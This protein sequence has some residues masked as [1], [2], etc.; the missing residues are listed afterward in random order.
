MCIAPS[1][2]HFE[3]VSF[4]N[5]IWTIKGGAHVA[6]VVDQIAKYMMDQLQ[7]GS[8]GKGKQLKPMHVKNQLFVFV[9]A[10]IENP[11]F[12]SQTSVFYSL[13]ESDLVLNEF[14]ATGKKL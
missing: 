11:A 13:F 1:D 2:G 12:D 3:Q 4:V 7:K 5:S 9:S 14:D 10:L 6:V 8:K